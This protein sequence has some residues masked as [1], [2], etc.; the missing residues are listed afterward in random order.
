M[1]SRLP[2]SF[3]RDIKDREYLKA[4]QSFE[5]FAEEFSKAVNA[6]DSARVR[7][8]IEPRDG[9][10][11]GSDRLLKQLRCRRASW[12]IPTATVLL[13]KFFN[14]LMGIRAQYYVSPYHGRAMNTLLLFA[15]RRRLLELVHTISPSSDSKLVEFSLDA[16]S[17]KI[18]ISERDLK[19][20]KIIRASDTTLSEEEIQNDWLTLARAVKAGAIEPG[21]FQLYSAALSGVRAP[22]ADQSEV[23]GAWI[24]AEDC[25]EY[26]TPDK[27]DR[28]CQLFMFGFT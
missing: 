25:S 10:Y 24:S 8:C 5:S 26:V 22:V 21:Q 6:V 27:R 28:E 9:R 18:W 3:G 12:I 4:G 19:G 2:W 16:P 7:F 11:T 13:D 23:K 15:L 14:G 1:L 20:Q 17:A